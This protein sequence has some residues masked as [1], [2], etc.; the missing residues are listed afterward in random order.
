MEGSQSSAEADDGDIGE[1]MVAE[2]WSSVPRMAVIDRG[3]DASLS[4]V[5]ILCLVVGCVASGFGSLTFLSC[6]CC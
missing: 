4:E 3:R 1:V 5:P 2:F 6:C